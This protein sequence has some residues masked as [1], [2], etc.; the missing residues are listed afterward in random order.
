MMDML[1][2]L[3]GDANFWV[4]I[5]SV[6]C[7]GFI[8]MKAAGPITGAL[9]GRTEAIRNRLAEA[10]ALRTE[11]QKLLETYQAKYAEALQEAENVM[12]TAQRR[13]DQMRIDMEEELKQ[14]I[15]RQERN[16][17]NRIARMEEETIRVVREAVINAAMDKVKTTVA[18]D[19][20]AASIDNAMDDLKKVL[21]K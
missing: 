12:A 10:E 2:H 9:D 4:M 20:K 5:S 8:A 14:T 15:A 13:A 7:F 16:A 19:S 11:A 3:T 1:S 21:Q 6:L 17:A 18:N